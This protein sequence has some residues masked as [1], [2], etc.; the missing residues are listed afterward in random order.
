MKEEK[1]LTTVNLIFLIIIIIATIGV[2]IHFSVGDE[3]VITRVSK[4]EEEF[5]KTEILDEINF[6]ITQKYLGTYKNEAVNGKKIEEVYNKD[7]AINYLKEKE[8]IEE[9][10]NEEGKKEENKYY[11]KVEN[12]KKDINQGKGQNGS[13]K[14][15]YILEKSDKTD[16]YTLFYIKN[17]EEKINIGN[18]QFDPELNK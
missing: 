1:G 3:G 15:I 9:Y 5:N 13:I 16:D 14:D 7:V 12:L 17:N 2:I 18:L 11:V 4:N 10:S 6:A 8:I